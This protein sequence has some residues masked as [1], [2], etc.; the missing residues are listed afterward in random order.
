M[1]V[2]PGATFPSHHSPS[3]L[4]LFGSVVQRR[5]SDL[6][7]FP[8]WYAFSR[9]P[10]R[11]AFDFQVLWASEFGVRSPGVE[12]AS[13]GFGGR[14]FGF[15]T[16]KDVFFVLLHEPCERKVGGQL[17]KEAWRKPGHRNPKK[18]KTWETTKTTWKGG[19][20]K[21]GRKHS[22]H[23]PTNESCGAVDFVLQP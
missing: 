18:R 4:P 15:S 16:M 19:R 7:V 17:D 12:A 1:L 21:I 20:A 9:G 5:P 10:K 13:P 11:L 14:G 6:L 2:K 3:R 22:Q 8:F 23:L